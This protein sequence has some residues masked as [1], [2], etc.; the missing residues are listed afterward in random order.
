MGRLA[1]SNAARSLAAFACA[2]AFAAAHAADAVRGAGLYASRCG[3]CHSLDANRVGPMHQGVFG[4]EA[5]SVTNYDYSPAL[6]GSGVV[7][8][9][10][11][12]DRWLADPEALVP[13][14]R[15]GY[16]LSDATERADVIEY[17]REQSP[18]VK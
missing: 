9:A 1:I 12:L 5:G 6:K 8:N 4:R 18:V 15:M 13:G 14:Q 10:T 2:A 7:W 11:T 17:L 16:Q 3:A